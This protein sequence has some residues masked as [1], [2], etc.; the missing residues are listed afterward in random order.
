MKPRA[1]VQILEAEGGIP[2]VT[3]CEPAVVREV[4]KA[5]LRS[6]VSYGYSKDSLLR[7]REEARRE[8][9]E[10]L[11][12]EEGARSATPELAEEPAWFSALNPT[13]QEDINTGV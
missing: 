5:I 11:A 12:Q 2:V 10:M 13:G 3:V 8:V 6:Q 1:L 9:L 7:P 4:A